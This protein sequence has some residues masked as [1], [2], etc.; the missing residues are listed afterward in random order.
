VILTI[1]IA[2]SIF[3][4]KTMYHFR[5][6][7]SG[8]LY[9]SG[10]LSVIGLH[11]VHAL[12]NVK[13]IINLRTDTEMEEEW[14][15]EEKRFAQANGVNLIDISM[16]PDTPPTEAQIEKFLSVVTDAAMLPVLVHC[17]M[18]VIRTGMMVSVYRIAVMQESNQKVLEELHMFGRTF[19]RR[20]AVKEF[21]L[22]YTPSSN[23]PARLQNRS[24][25]I[26]K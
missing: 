20:P 1:V 26:S 19:S 3:W 12:Y 9:R 7:D 14:Y 2:A 18:G 23:G 6:V 10:T 15:K 17:E 24:N 4:H 5:V 25:Q 8:K 16:L 22:N 11:M 21:I 13:T